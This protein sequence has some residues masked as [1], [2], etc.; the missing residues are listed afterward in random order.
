M[1]QKMRAFL[2]I[3]TAIII[4]SAIYFVT[5]HYLTNPPQTSAGAEDLAKCL[6]QK[7]A[8]L[9]GAYW[10]PHCQNQKALF[11]NA[12]QYLTYVECDAGGENPNPQAC[13][14]AGVQAYPTWKING[15]NYQ[16]EKTFDQLKSLS[17][18]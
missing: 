15:V 6:T 8:V 16:G 17:G 9:Y 12:S 14:T 10:C 11:G 13:Q 3:I 2:T 5:E 18:C 4:V 1:K 7:S